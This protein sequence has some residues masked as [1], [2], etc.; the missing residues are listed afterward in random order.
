LIIADKG[1]EQAV[2]YLPIRTGLNCKLGKLTNKAVA[3]AHGMVY[4]EA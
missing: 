1:I 2:Q 4:S 3:E